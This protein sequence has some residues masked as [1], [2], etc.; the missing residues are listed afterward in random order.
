[1]TDREALLSFF[2]MPDNALKSLRSEVQISMGEENARGLLERYGFRCGEEM[3]TIMGT[4]CGTMAELLKTI[5]DIWSEIGLGR[6][7]IR[8]LAE[9]EIEFEF[10]ESFEATSVGKVKKP[11]CNFTAGYIAGLASGLTDHKYHCVEE[12]CLSVGDPYCYHHL[13][14]SSDALEPGKED[15]ID[16]EMKYDLERGLSY[17][18]K[19]ETPRRAYDVFLDFLTHGSPGFCITREFPEKIRNKY[20]LTKT[21]ILWLSKSGRE[22]SIKPTMLGNLYHLLENFLK[23]ADNSIVLLSGLEYLITQNNFTQ[24]LKFIQLINDQIAIHN[25]ILLVPISHLTLE[26]R[27]LKNV[28]RE[29][30]EIA[31]KGKG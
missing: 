18:I 2:I 14:P 21:P 11:T 4:K 13:S 15:S 24:V 5:Q 3:A 19:E 8:Q 1:M 6:P 22:N 9:N 29:L 25:S 30:A 10:T 23:R 27:D 28:E 31:E 20:K 26:K 7:T 17:I 16:E 12:K